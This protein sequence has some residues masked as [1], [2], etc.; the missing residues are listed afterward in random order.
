MKL[1][2]YKINQIDTIFRKIAI[3]LVSCRKAK[4]PKL[5]VESAVTN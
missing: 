3:V 5:S 2:K 1:F 4:R